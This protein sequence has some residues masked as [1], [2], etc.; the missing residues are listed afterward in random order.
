MK[1]M[2]EDNSSLKTFSEQELLVN[3][4]LNIE[5]AKGL[6]NSANSRS[7]DVSRD[8]QSLENAFI[9]YMDRVDSIERDIGLIR[10]F[11]KLPWYKRLF[12]RTKK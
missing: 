8:L 9:K 2:S 12:W 7:L 11:A 3:I 6:A 4:R 1:Q 10:E 5:K